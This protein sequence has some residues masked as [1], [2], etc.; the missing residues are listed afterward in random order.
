M[1]RLFYAMYS[2][3]LTAPLNKQQVNVL[4]VYYV[5]LTDRDKLSARYTSV[6][7][8]GHLTEKYKGL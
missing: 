8:I 7:L 1:V 3:I 6:R 4:K 5:L 2:G